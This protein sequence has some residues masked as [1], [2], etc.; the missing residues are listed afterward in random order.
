MLHAP[1]WLVESSRSA[2]STPPPGTVQLSR[3]AAQLEVQVP[4]E[5]TWA[6]P[7]VLPQAPQCSRSLW[8]ETHWVPLP[9]VQACWPAG[10]VTSHMPPEQ[11]SP[12]LQALSQAP[13]WLGSTSRLT[14]TSPQ[15][16]V[17]GPQL[18]P[19]PP[20]T[21]GATWASLPGTVPESVVVFPPSAQAQSR[22]KHNTK[23][24]RFTV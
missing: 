19:V 17:P 18:G 20:S 7:Q 15:A 11:R 8:V 10:Q 2:H 1:Q 23:R 3:P 16:V 21:P 5:Q 4:S 9:T 14:Q 24:S 22:D 6:A 12:S 13:Q